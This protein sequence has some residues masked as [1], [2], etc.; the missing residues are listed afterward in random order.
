[1]LI[2]GGGYGSVSGVTEV[3]GE[4]NTVSSWQVVFSKDV[5]RSRGLMSAVL[6]V[7]DL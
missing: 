1:M 2:A 7:G 6:L 5:R 3:L 4:S